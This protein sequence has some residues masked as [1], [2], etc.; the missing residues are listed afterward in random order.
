VL[1]QGTWHLG[2]GRHPHSEELRALQAGID[3]G[4]TLIDTAEM[5]GAGAAEELVGEAIAGRRDEVFLVSKV[6]PSHASR[7][8]TA[9]ACRASLRRLGT[10]R[11]DLYLLHWRGMIPLQETVAGFEDLRAAGLVRNWGVSNF[12]V[13]HL[14]RLMNIP[15]G[16]A[17][18]TD[19]VLY[20]LSRRGIETRLL[21]WCLRRGMPIMAY[22][23]LDQ[24]RLLEHPVLWGIAYQYRVKPAEVALA[25]V[26][27]HAGV[28]AIPEA[29]TVEHVRQNRAALG[30]QLRDIDM[31]KLEEAFPPPIGPQPLETL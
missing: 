28:C 7:G 17:V 27:A 19:Q 9:A 14:E 16:G 1:G 10:D 3:L 5:Y 11:L 26:L 13:P 29:G 8:G 24:G 21:P 30:L 22:S 4:M 18:Q 31:I 25:W 12:D 6:L 20:N 23:P 2:Q 15:A